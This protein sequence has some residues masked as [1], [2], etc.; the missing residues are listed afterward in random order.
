MSSISC[1][2]GRPL[3][4]SAPEAGTERG[5]RA[6]IGQQHFPQRR[7]KGPAQPGI[8]DKPCADRRDPDRDKYLHQRQIEPPVKQCSHQHRYSQRHGQRGQRQDQNEGEGDRRQG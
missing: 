3:P 2:V 7:I 1:A 5:Q 4:R 8:G 6:T